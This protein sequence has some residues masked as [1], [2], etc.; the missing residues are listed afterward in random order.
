MAF[1]IVVAG[2]FV[3]P[4]VLKPQV[5]ST[6]TCSARASTC[7]ALATRPGG[8]SLHAPIDRCRRASVQSVSLSMNGP[9]MGSSQISGFSIELRHEPTS[10]CR[11][12]RRSSLKLHDRRLKVVRDGVRPGDRRASSTLINETMARRFFLADPV[13]SAGHDASSSARQILS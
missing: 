6:A 9:V 5:D 4:R 13:A 2:L 1:F 8:R 12:T 3:K 11:R 10:G 7:E